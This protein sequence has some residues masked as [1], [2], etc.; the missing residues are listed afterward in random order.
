MCRFTEELVGKSGMCRFT[1]ELVGK[2]EI[3][4]PDKLSYNY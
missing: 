4:L 2:S 1:E 3:A